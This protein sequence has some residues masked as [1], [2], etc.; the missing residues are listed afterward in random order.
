MTFLPI[1]ERELRVAARRRAIYWMRVVIALASI[2]IGAC[3]FLAY[4]GEPEK[5]IGPRIF[6]G[7]SILALGYC[8]LAGR[9]FTVDCI[10]SEKREGTLG[11]LFL[12]DLKGFDVIL[13][14]LAAT[15]LNGFFSLLA[16]LPVL[17][18]PLLMGGTSNGQ[19]WRMALILVVT[20]LFSLSL[21]I[22]GSAGHTNLRHAA[23]SNIGLLLLFTVCLPLIGLLPL[24]A[25]GLGLNYIAW[26]F[27]YTSPIFAF[28]T[29]FDSNY[30]VQPNGFWI[31]VIFVNAITLIFIYRAARVV[32]HSWQERLAPPHKLAPRRTLQRALSYEEAAR[33]VAYRCRLLNVN[34]FYW[35]AARDR[36]KPVQVW[37][38]LA[39]AFMWWV[40]GWCVQGGYWFDPSVAITT[41]LIVNA[42]LKVWIALEAGH[43]LAEDKKS[44]A[45]ELLLCSPLTVREIIRGQWLALRRQFL[46]P[47]L[48]VT[49]CELL[50]I[51]PEP[52]FGQDHGRGPLIITIVAGLIM[53]AVDSFTLVL[54]A[55]KRALSARSFAH[56]G[57]GTVMWI[58]FMPWVIL[59]AAAVGINMLL[60][61]VGGEEPGWTFYVGLWFGLGL[62]VDF[63]FGASA[64]WLLRSD[65][66]SLAAN[67]FSAA[68]V[69]ARDYDMP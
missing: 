43:R 45:I 69:S 48:F 55:M 64:W 27:C 32:P 25:F 44:G 67:R 6:L 5:D 53:F 52:P 29:A 15:S 61:D 17:A 58:L 49:T 62:L 24:M 26:P 57:G 21:G 50:L 3:I 41:S 22:H 65:F 13:G 11:L 51:L 38:F 66:R 33:R 1:V 14:K 12:T 56:A 42:T 47:I 23:A 54:V 2:I 8:L 59:I 60:V 19:F 10:S 63:I 9:W 37:I 4:L 35:L 46:L 20:F 34:P 18:I 31:S 40:A 7:L 30:A 16:L 68:S 39:F 28:V 36:R